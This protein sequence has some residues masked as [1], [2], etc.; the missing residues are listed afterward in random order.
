MAASRYHSE[1]VRMSLEQRDLEKR[2][3]TAWIE[4]DT[5]VDNMRFVNDS[6][7]K[8]LERIALKHGVTASSVLKWYE[9]Q[10]SGD[11]RD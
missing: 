4:Y 3:R 1:L 8:Y 2:L 6:R 5:T 7:W 11:I 10:P 9:Y